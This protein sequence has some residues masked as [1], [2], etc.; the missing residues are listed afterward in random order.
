[1]KTSFLL[2]VS[3]ALV[4]AVALLAGSAARAQVAFAITVNTTPLIGHAAGPFYLD[5]Q[6]NDGAGIG[7]GNNT[8]VVNGFNFGGG[9]P[10]GGA[11]VF[12]GVTGNLSS[13]VSLRDTSPFN[14]FFQAFTPGTSLKFFVT[15]SNTLSTPVPDSFSFAILDSDL[16]NIPTNAPG[17]DALV[18][19]DISGGPVS[20]HSYA[21]S[22]TI[23]PAAGGPPIA[24]G[25][26]AVAAVPEPSTYGVLGALALLGVVA[27][28]RRS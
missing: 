7:N 11:T 8:A 9:A 13:S 21:G 20:V 3:A 24:I 28:K 25:A 5:F 16:F 14:E 2:R 22:S 1:M 12:G 6:L 15:L 23:P 10:L 4:C 26:P 18:T 17:T 27:L 19:F